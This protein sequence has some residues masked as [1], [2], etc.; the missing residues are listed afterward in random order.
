MV[1]MLCAGSTCFPGP[2]KPCLRPLVGSPPRCVNLLCRL[3]QLWLCPHCLMEFHESFY[4]WHVRHH[5]PSNGGSDA[6][7]NSV[8]EGWLSY[9]VAGEEEEESEG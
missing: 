2:S 4:D 6:W 5:C 9:E 1:G 7:V 8:E 3:F